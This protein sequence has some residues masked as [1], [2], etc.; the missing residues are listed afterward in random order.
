MTPGGHHL[1]RREVGVCG[2]DDFTLGVHPRVG[3]GWLVWFITQSGS[4]FIG[5]G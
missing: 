3:G 1:G 4:W 5:D 2:I